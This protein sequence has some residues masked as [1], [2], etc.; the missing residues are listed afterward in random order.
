MSSN[1]FL[2]T[3]LFITTGFRPNIGGLETHLDDLCNY[4]IKRN[5]RVYVIAPQPTITKVLGERIERKS[6]L[7]IH[8]VYLFGHLF[9][10]LESY[11]QLK[12]L[13]FA[14]MLLIYSL[15]FMLKYHK[16][17]DV[18]HA[19]GIISAFIVKIL[20]KFFKKRTIISLHTIYNVDK[21]PIL[22]KMLKTILNSFNT[23]LT[24]SNR[25]KKELTYIGLDNKKI[26]VFTHWVNQEV[27]KP[28]DK[29]WCKRKLGWNDKFIVLFV[30]RLVEIKG[31]RL[32]IDIA[33]EFSCEKNVYFVFIGEGPLVKDM[34]RSNF[35]KNVI[36]LG[37][38]G[39]KHLAIC[40]NAAD[41]VVV[42]SI[43]DE[44]F[45][46][47]LPEA[48]SCGTPV[49]ATNRSGISEILEPSVSVLVEP[50]VDKIKSQIIY[51]FKNRNE[52]LQMSKN[53][54]KFAEMLFSE[55]NAKIIEESYKGG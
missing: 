4:L 31:V 45:G 52:L 24:L 29:I 48:L 3:I 19:H 33:K 50:D 44:P 12:F 7:E 6:N 39:E 16:K 46:R 23:I 28:L 17:I 20:V 53:C 43:Y 36:Y 41:L 54:R 47:V 35:Y 9:Y 42:P 38:V 37:N 18:I 13:Y 8:R 22:I 30:G 40:Y 15:F 26:K 49:I 25:S 11:P 32:L 1:T 5:Y 51:F 55:R 27:F 34:L 2:K 14:P 21:K 10:K